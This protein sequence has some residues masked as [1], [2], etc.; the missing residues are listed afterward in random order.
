MLIQ[1]AWGAVHASGS[2]FHSFFLRVSA[3]RGQKKAIV[4]VARKLLT[5]IYAI[6]RDRSEYRPMGD[7]TNA[8]EAYIHKMAMLEMRRHKRLEKM[9]ASQGIDLKSITDKITQ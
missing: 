1:A 8:T 2:L 4:A 3:R 5:V 9:A 7:K 6:P